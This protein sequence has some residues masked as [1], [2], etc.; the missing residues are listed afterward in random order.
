MEEIAT[1]A[2]PRLIRRFCEEILQKSGEN[3]EED[4]CTQ[5]IPFDYTPPFQTA[6]PVGTGSREV[7][8]DID[9]EL[10][11]M[12][13]ACNYAVHA[14][15]TYTSKVLNSVQARRNQHCPTYRLPNE[16]ITTIFHFAR[17][18]SLGSNDEL[19]RSA[20]VNLS[21]V[22]R[23]WRNIALSIPA[24]WTKIDSQNVIL[25]ELFAKRSK[26]EL[27]DIDVNMGVSSTTYGLNSIRANHLMEF[28]TP[29]IDR[30]ESFVFCG[31]CEYYPLDSP[32][33]NLQTLQLRADWNSQH[34]YFNMN[35]FSNHT[36]LLH[37]LKLSRFY[38]SLGAHLH[39]GLEILHLHNT[40]IFGVPDEFAATS[41]AACPLLRELVLHD[42]RFNEILDQAL[43]DRPV[44]LRHLEV[45]RLKMDDQEIRSL[46]ASV[47]M[48]SSL[49]FC[50]TMDNNHLFIIFPLR[51]SLQKYP[52]NIAAI[53]T[54]SI[55]AD[56]TDEA[57]GVR[58]IGEN[59]QNH[60]SLLELHFPEF[61]TQRDGVEIANIPAYFGPVMTLT[62]LLIHGT[63][64]R[65]IMNED[66][67]NILLSH[68]LAL[69]TISL[70]SVPAA[71]VEVLV[72][73]Y[74][75]PYCPLLQSLHL[76]EVDLG[77]ADLT[78]RRLA[79][80][81]RHLNIEGC[82]DLSRIEISNCRGVDE[83]MVVGLRGLSVEVIW[84]GE[85][86]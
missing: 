83:A 57:G 54:L 25:A 33:P 50:I 43:G 79:E 34:A 56:P 84:D 35:I 41:L 67:F 66:A 24:L 19:L 15:V 30:W 47:Q 77:M 28:L 14:M 36:P 1:D 18:C 78:L 48:P 72:I 75:T 22:S 42:V 13:R 6:K 69:T 44:P 46:I 2:I 27:L 64:D 16:I 62:T 58:A 8:E 26:N 61:H 55:T 70:R 38:L 73:T 11:V 40:R 3:A 82:R 12:T 5:A 71:L 29:H 65:V 23:W 17:Q 53:D 74:T 68:S 86:S 39:A 76:Q 7:L 45:M 52:S 59:S 32:A 81:R 85:G 63:S 21:Q 4:L 37:N 49:R 10:K 9:E 80:S 60:M 31:N 51:Q 20:P